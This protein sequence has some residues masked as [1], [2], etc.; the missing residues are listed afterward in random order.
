MLVCKTQQGWYSPPY[1]HLL[2]LASLTLLSRCS[3]SLA[4][5]LACPLIA[6]HSLWVYAL[7]RG[8]K[9]VSTITVR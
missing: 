7:S 8:H 3:E 9:I 5:C 6:E 1:D 2:L 4:P